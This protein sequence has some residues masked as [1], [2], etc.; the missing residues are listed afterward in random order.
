MSASGASGAVKRGAGGVFAL[1]R[2]LAGMT[3][4]SRALGFGRDVLMATMLG[5][6]ACADA[7]LLA[8]TLPNLARRV[9]GE[10]AFASALVPVFLEARA[11][12]DQ[13]GARRLVGAAVARLGIGLCAL[14]LALEL[15]CAAAR[16]DAG[17]AALAGLGVSA[18]ALQR[19]DLALDLTQVLLP[20]L[21]FVCLAGVLGG[22]LHALGRFAVPAMAP[23]TLNAAWIG[24][25]LL[26][27]PYA[28]DPMTLAR[29]L[30]CALTV[31]GGIELLAHLR[32]LRRAGVPV[33]PATPDPEAWAR[34]QR[35]FGGLLLGAGL[36]QVNA[37]MDSFVA[38][39]LVPEGGTSALFY[40]NRLAQL[41]IGVLGVALSTAIFPELAR[42]AKQGD[43]AGAGAL[44]DRGLSVAMF[45]ALPG[46]FLLAALAKPIVDVLFLRGAFDAAAAER[47]ATVVLLLAPAVVAGCAT[48][49]LTRG[50][51]AE[52]EVRL[53]VRVAAWTV[54]L[55]VALGLSLVGF[56]A[57]AGLALAT[58]ISQVASLCVLAWLS[59]R[60]R[61]ARGETPAG[62]EA[63]R[64]VGRA[65]ALSLVLA[66][67]ALGVERLVP[68]PAAVRLVVA[69]VA[70]GVAFGAGAL[71]LRSPEL[72]ALRGR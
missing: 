19:A 37:L 26:F 50:L 58:S 12:G 20:Y 16:S 10:G 46:A 42:R 45:L 4:M 17:Q 25:L 39:A 7:F 14:T 69:V 72:T 47:T 61:V 64:A 11:R 30:A 55:N 27:G 36:F 13:D 5:A 38:Y 48:P 21:P 33:A 28:H 67:V 54:A 56:M 24:A 70:G 68:G 52:E 63:A 57:E 23:V 59:R 66:L 51:H 8:W 43:L 3:L 62:A 6:G 31:T 34:L 2:R 29:L 60:R 15:A 40:A 49:V 65:V 32:D 71:W 18:A 44:V 41:P 53:P 22:A 1:V 9:F 35:M